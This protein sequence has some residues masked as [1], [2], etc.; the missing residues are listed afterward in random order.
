MAI[1]ALARMRKGL[2]A[3]TFDAPSQCAKQMYDYA[4]DRLF[5]FALLHYSGS[6]P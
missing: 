5:N 4:A 6:P 2:M 3:A 1:G